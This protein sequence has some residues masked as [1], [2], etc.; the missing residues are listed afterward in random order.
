MRKERN[1]MSKNRRGVQG[2]G[3]TFLLFGLLAIATG[4]IMFFGA[5]DV[6]LHIE[7]GTQIAQMF[8]IILAAIGV[9]QFICGFVGMRA[10][11]HDKLLMPFAWL[12]A[13]VIIVN[14]AQAG[15]SFTTGEGEIWQNL[16]YAAVALSGI[17]FVSR[18]LK[19]IAAN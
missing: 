6:D 7:D 19:E 11:K 5:N 10:A 8:G 17:I 12:C 15:L 14:L 1:N 9:F 4:A 2:I 13:F 16:L 3:F 18:S